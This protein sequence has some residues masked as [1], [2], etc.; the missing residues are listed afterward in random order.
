[1]E[2]LG[3]IPND[4]FVEKRPAPIWWNH[5]FGQHIF[6]KISGLVT[7]DFRLCSLEAMRFSPTSDIVSKMGAQ[8]P[9]VL[10]QVC[11]YHA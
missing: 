6:A 9:E 8:Y 2:H 7:L 3:S 11:T 10:M 1:M 4:H 5:D